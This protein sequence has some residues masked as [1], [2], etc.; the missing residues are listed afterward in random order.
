[1]LAGTSTAIEIAA[2]CRLNQA[3][4]LN[5]CTTIWLNHA[6]FD[7]NRYFNGHIVA[8]WASFVF[9]RVSP[10]LQLTTS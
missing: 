10:F 1:M 5:K 2:R 9:L 4:C 3:V 7:D 8:L 6:S